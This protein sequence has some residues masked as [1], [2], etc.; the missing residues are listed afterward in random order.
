MFELP[1]PRQSISKNGVCHSHLKQPLK[2]GETLNHRSGLA[3]WQS[4]RVDFYHVTVGAYAGPRKN[5]PRILASFTYISYLS[6]S[7][8]VIPL[9]VMVPLHPSVPHDQQ[10]DVD[11]YQTNQ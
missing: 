8:F 11:R 6:P 7:C 1:P 10:V 4:F 3:T 9:D 2:I 5:N